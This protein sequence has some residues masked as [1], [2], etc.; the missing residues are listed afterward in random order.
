[1]LLD[2]QPRFLPDLRFGVAEVRDVADLHL[3][4]MTDPAAV[5]RR[6]IACGAFS[7]LAEIAGILRAELGPEAARVGHR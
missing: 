2:G 4:A 7:S 3:R 5:G 1:M 6:F